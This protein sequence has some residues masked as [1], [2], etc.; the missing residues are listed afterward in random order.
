MLV[1]QLADYPGRTRVDFDH[2]ME[3]PDG[4]LRMEIPDGD[5]SDPGKRIRLLFVHVKG[6][7]Y[8][9]QSIKSTNTQVGESKLCVR[10]VFPYL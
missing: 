5:D 3:I 2:R 6:I 1:G 7:P 10:I 8:G 9:T 4:G